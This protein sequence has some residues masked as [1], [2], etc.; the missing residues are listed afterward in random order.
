MVNLQKHIFNQKPTVEDMIFYLRIMQSR[1]VFFDEMFPIYGHDVSE[2]LACVE[3][4]V[5]GEIIA[6]LETLE[7]PVS[8]ASPQSLD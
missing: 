1:T 8:Q 2:S 7:Q 4:Y 5:L 6:L 3:H